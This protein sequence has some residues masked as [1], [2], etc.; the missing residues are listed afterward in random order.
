M[1]RISLEEAKFLQYEMLKEIHRYT[2]SHSLTY[3]LSAGTLLG[4][5]RHQGFIP[6]DDDIDIIMPQPDFE[7]LMKN[8]KS[9]RYQAVWCYNNMEYGYVFGRLY[10]KRTCFQMGRYK[11]LGLYID[12]YVI[13]GAPEAKELQLERFRRAFKYLPR[14]SR[15]ISLRSKLVRLGIWPYKTL[16]F[17]LLNKACRRMYEELARY[18]YNSSIFVHPY[19]GGKTI[20]RKEL[21]E[22]KLIMP[23]ENDAFFVPERFDDLLSLTYGNYMQ[24]PPLE[25]RQAYH[26]LSYYY[27]L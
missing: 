3:F 6:W 15:L 8:Y 25:K 12:I 22:R 5:V 10:D 13:F 21:Y 26:D 14:R 23:F 1:K 9:D 2:E 16:D 18:D 17:T 19:G 11:G 27:W 7:M 4:A 24:L 20:V